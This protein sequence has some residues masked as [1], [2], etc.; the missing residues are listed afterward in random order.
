[1]PV[2]HRMRTI[3]YRRAEWFRRHQID[4]RDLL[5]ADVLRFIHRRLRNVE[6]RRV[7]GANG[8]LE[9]RNFSDGGADGVYVHI[10]S[11]TPGDQMSVVPMV[12]GVP[13]AGLGVVGAPEGSEF[14]DGDLMVKVIGDDVFLCR[15]GLHE[16]SFYNYVAQVA[17]RAGLPPASHSF[18]LMKRADVSKLRLIADEGVKSVRL[19]ASAYAATIEREHRTAAQTVLDTVSEAFMSIAG[20]EPSL[21]E[22]SEDEHLSVEVGFKF[23]RRKSRAYDQRRIVS[24]AQAVVRETGDDDDEGFEIETL[25][26]KRFRQSQILLAKKVSIEA[27]G[28]TVLH[29]A[30]WRALDDFCEELE[31]RGALV[32]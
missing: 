21:M 26:G 30:A 32:E 3:S 14:M 20:R 17:Q 5:L 22:V 13:N 7:G 25:R 1:M 2:R 8:W 12:Q 6:E 29:T 10:A 24:L 18:H 28:K 19:N 27:F 31:R 11:Y 16:N 4:G 9:G 15:S 23:D